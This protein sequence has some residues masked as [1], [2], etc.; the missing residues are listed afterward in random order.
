[1]VFLGL[2]VVVFG[3][4]VAMA[5]EGISF[6]MFIAPSALVMTIFVPFGGALMTYRPREIWDAFMAV[7]GGGVDVK[8][9]DR[10]TYADFF[11]MLSRY[12]MNAG[13]LA[14]VLG[15]VQVLRFIGVA[16]SNHED[17]NIGMIAGGA[18][19]GLIGLLYGILFNFLYDCM[20]R[21]MD[22]PAA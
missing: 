11:S 12:A 7:F 20:R 5:I 15:V 3:V 1:M 2:L 10:I 22:R 9:E 18:A 19:L 17:V 16:Q 21:K 6:F 14:V 8:R 4:C 13:G